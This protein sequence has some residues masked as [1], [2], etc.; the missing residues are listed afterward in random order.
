MTI[1]A[2]LDGFGRDEYT[3]VQVRCIL[4][5]VQGLYEDGEIPD[6][7]IALHILLFQLRPNFRVIALDWLN[8]DVKAY[9]LLDNQACLTK[10]MMSTFR[11]GDYI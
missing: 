1:L 2:F 6:P 8:F 9:R 7:D 10:S 3:P 4:N 11:Q 5:Y